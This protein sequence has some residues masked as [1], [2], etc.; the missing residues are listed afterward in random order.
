MDTAHNS[1]DGDGFWTKLLKSGYS[2]ILGATLDLI[3]LPILL[4]FYSWILNPILNS[5]FLGFCI[6]I[7]MLITGS[8]I[9]GVKIGRRPKPKAQGAVSYWHPTWRR[10][11]IRKGGRLD[12]WITMP[13]MFLMGVGVLGFAILGGINPASRSPLT[14]TIFGGL[15]LFLVGVSSWFMGAEIQN[16]RDAKRAMTDAL[17]ARKQSCLTALDK[18]YQALEYVRSQD[19]KR[20]LLDTTRAQIRTLAFEKVKV[21]GSKRDL[22]LEWDSEIRDNLDKFF[23]L[24]KK[25]LS[26]SE[27]VAAYS[28][29]IVYLLQRNDGKTVSAMRATL[30]S[31][32]DS[33]YPSFSFVDNPLN[34]FWVFSAMAGLHDYDEATVTRLIDDALKDDWRLIAF[35]RSLEFDLLKALQ[36]RGMTPILRIHLAKKIN[37]LEGTD[38][39]AAERAKQL[40]GVI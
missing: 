38:P 13:A 15:A 37:D 2:W 4:T 23:Q 17:F 34:R 10:P 19:S 40:A 12:F 3:G 9:L 33:A 14:Y 30:A 18:A 29:Q 28:E 16:M 27:T 20:V 21:K 11:P 1:K 26:D 25:D 36:E 22:T 35:R 32:F 8:L 5:T 7:A 6:G 39:K 24:I 31:D